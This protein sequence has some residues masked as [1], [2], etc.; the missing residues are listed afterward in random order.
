MAFWVICADQQILVDIDA[1]RRRMQHAQSPQ[2]RLRLVNILDGFLPRAAERRGC[3]R[4]AA[5][6]AAGT[7]AFGRN[8]RALA[9]H[10]EAMNPLIHARSTVEGEAAV[11]SAS[12]NSSVAATC[13]AVSKMDQRC[14][15]ALNA[16][17][18]DDTFS[19]VAR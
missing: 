11:V 9:V 17:C 14:G 3:F 15:A 1:S 6:A 4:D 8:E 10:S 2:I 16:A 19:S 5:K 13:S 7:N 12:R 18:A